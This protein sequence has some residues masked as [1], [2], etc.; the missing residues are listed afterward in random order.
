MTVVGGL[1]SVRNSVR[2]SE[3]RSFTRS[4]QHKVC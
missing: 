1:E 2:F 3:A 4:V